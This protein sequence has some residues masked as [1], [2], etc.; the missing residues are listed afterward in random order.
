MIK[1][2]LWSY[3]LGKA[4]GRKQGG[5]RLE[6]FFLFLDNLYMIDLPRMFIKVAGL[7]QKDSD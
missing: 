1:V 3:S 2:M 4:R 5:K 6:Q 7:T